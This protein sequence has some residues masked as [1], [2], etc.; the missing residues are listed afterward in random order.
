LLLTP[1]WSREISISLLG[2]AAAGEFTTDTD[3]PD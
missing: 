3:P 1:S 2:W